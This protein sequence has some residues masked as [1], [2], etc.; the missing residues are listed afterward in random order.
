MTQSSDKN[1]TS[2]VTLIN[3]GK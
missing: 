3:E 1:Q 2:L